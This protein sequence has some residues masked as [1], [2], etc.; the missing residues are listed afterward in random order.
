MIDLPHPIGGRYQPLEQL[1]RGA[2]A[3][4]ALVRDR[5]R[6]GPP[7]ALKRVTARRAALLHDEFRRL[8][9]L[10]CPGIPRVDELGQDPESGDWLFTCEPARGRPWHEELRGAP[11][12]VQQRACADLLRTLAL[13]E[14]RGVVHRDLKPDH[15]LVEG[16]ATPRVLLLDFGLATAGGAA[17]AAGSLPYLAPEL[18]RGAPASHASDLY[19][20]G[21]VL[22]ELWCGGAPF[23]ADSPA[24]WARAHLEQPVLFPADFA[25][26][27]ALR[28]IVARLLAKSPA[29]RY[30]HA[31]EVLADLSRVAPEPLPRYTPATLLGRIRSVPPF[32]PPWHEQLATGDARPGGTVTW[33]TA[34]TRA[35][36][37]ALLR[38]LRATALL[39][40]AR[41]LLVACAPAEGAAPLAETL[42]EQLRVLLDAPPDADVE[43]LLAQLQRGESTHRLVLFLEELPQRRA[44]DE[45]LLGFLLRARVEVVCSGAGAARDDALLAAACPTAEELRTLT[46]RALSFDELAR[47][48]PGW[49]GGPL[50]PELA[51][52]LGARATAAID[53]S[54]VVELLCYAVDAGALTADFGGLHFDP[55]RVDLA[56]AQGDLLEVVKRRWR[57]VTGARRA[58]L[59]ALALLD[60]DAT[61]AQVAALAP[62]ASRADLEA[63]EAAGLVLR[64]GAAWRCSESGVAAL[65][66]AEL[67]TERARPLHA[68]AA[69]ALATDGGEGVAGRR[70]RHAFL[71]AP[72]DV[73]AA[74]AYAIEALARVDAQRLAEGDAAAREVEAQ[75]EDETARRR[76]ALVRGI[77]ELRRGSHAAAAALLA[78]LPEQLDD[79]GARGRALI[80]HARALDRCGRP[81]EALARLDA[82]PERLGERAPGAAAL[83][84]FLLHQLQRDAE[85]EAVCRV[86]F[87]Q[88]RVAG[89]GG[90]HRLR[91]IHAITL[92]RLAR[93]GEAREAFAAALA[94]ARA[95]GQPLQVATIEGNLARFEEDLGHPEAAVAAFRRA[96]AAA[97]AFG[98]RQQEAI[99]ALNFAN[100][101]FDLGRFVEC[102]QELQRSREIAH[103]MARPNVLR[104]LELMQAHVALNEG[105][106]AAAHAALD[107]CVAI[108]RQIDDAPGAWRAQLVRT[109]VLLREGRGRAARALVEQVAADPVANGHP[110]LQALV[111]EY[112]LQWATFAGSRRAVEQ[113]LAAAP[114]DPASRRRRLFL[115]DARLSALWRLGRADELA[116]AAADQLADLEGSDYAALRARAAAMAAFAAARTGSAAAPARLEQARAAYDAAQAPGFLAQ[117]AE[118]ALVLGVVSRDARLLEEAE[119]FA[120]RAGHRPLERRARTLR[121]RLAPPTAAHHDAAT[122]GRP[123]A[124]ERLMQVA[125]EISATLDGEQLLRLVLDHAVEATRAAR[126]F[127]ILGRGGELGVRVARNLDAADIERPELSFSS[128][129]ARKVARDGTAVL[130]SDVSAD[131]EWRDAASISQLKL[132]SVLCVPLRS[133]NEVIG[134]LYLDEP[135]R[136]DAFRP[137]DLRYVENLSDFAAIALQKADLL[138]ANRA[139]EADLERNQQEI[140]RLNRE[141]QKALLE[142]QGELRA[143]Q[144]SLDQARKFAG[145]VPQFEGIVA[146]SREM[147]EVKRRIELFAD[148]ELPVLISG[149]SGTGKEL[150]ARALHRRSRRAEQPFEPLNC[151]TTQPALIENELF[152]HQKGAYTGATEEQQG[153]FERADGGTLFLDEVCEA[154]PELQAKLLRAVQSGEVQRLGGGPVRKVDVRIVAAS[155]KDVRKEVAAGRFREDLMY[156]LMV[157]QVHL[158]ALRERR[159]DVPLLLDHFVARESAK[160]K[161]PPPSFTPLAWRRLVLHDWP[162]N[163]RELEHAVQ[164]LLVLNRDVAEIGIDALRSE[165]PSAVAGEPERL[166]PLKEYLEA[167]ERTY[168]QEVLARCAGNR[169]KAAREL[170]I[171]ER[172]LYQRL[173][174]LRGGEAEGG[175]PEPTGEVGESRF[176]TGKR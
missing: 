52:F 174:R 127:L 134:S 123:D 69:A 143:A 48:F 120:R 67:P 105:D 38:E 163:V 131:D 26:P 70:V 98:D 13:L 56:E 87:A 86:A 39:G 122:E 79:E 172:N 161:R 59:E 11:L 175:A 107:A 113:A 6:G 106:F 92:W 77:V 81:A 24:D 142:Q 50:T 114:A 124:L 125:K 121:R 133:K 44:A 117:K 170:G 119:E 116:Q 150:V 73:A 72:H 15:L 169:A 3:R 21:V 152:G 40:E 37:D 110:D 100:T 147:E 109:E 141:L 94:A 115:R 7:L 14:E 47:T 151:A 155:N 41:P 71:A 83:R 95:T 84:A 80:E 10:R 112:R 82:F 85:A 157:L 158:P 4:V 23:S 104:R 168:L 51:R 102:K 61:E 65:V 32:D 149:E 129:V 135:T 88:A 162:G 89:D 20:L 126:G 64:V 45:A 97:V 118:P 101:L 54:R 12:L 91:S 166:L 18:F 66:R 36:R 30:A 28:E 132:L 68:L 153:L 27:L 171:S 128:S 34:P 136:I 62:Q 8:Q 57:T 74:R 154:S 76:A 43:A 55:S 49:V 146:Q 165:L 160:L 96:L 138:A 9:S 93:F 90:D 63:L 53:V 16:G 176:E 17:P 29:E 144:A 173:S 108:A 35:G 111:G 78:P 22:F 137:S 167:Q 25:A 103:A 42:A 5:A 46:P 19:A 60:H 31:A 164:R 99:H 2:T 58:A 159:D 75:A 1:G 156:R 130:R 148:A 33:V 139:R 145:R 140:A